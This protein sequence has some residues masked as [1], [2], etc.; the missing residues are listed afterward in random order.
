MTQQN[1]PERLSICEQGTWK[2]TSTNPNDD[3]FVPTGLYEAQDENGTPYCIAAQEHGIEQWLV[4]N[5]YQDTGDGLTFNR[6][7]DQA[8][9]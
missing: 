9:L 7:P 4:D 6:A 1:L 2:P 5:G 8:S 3:E